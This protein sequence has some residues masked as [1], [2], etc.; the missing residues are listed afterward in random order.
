MSSMRKLKRRLLVWR[1]YEARYYADGCTIGRDGG[2]YDR[3]LDAYWNERLRMHQ[4]L[5]YAP[6]PAPDHWRLP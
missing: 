2:G 6:W 1:R 5:A 3:A 4:V